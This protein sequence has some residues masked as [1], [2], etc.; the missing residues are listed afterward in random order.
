VR[1]LVLKQLPIQSSS[2]SLFPPLFVAMPKERRGKGGRGRG[3]GRGGERRGRSICR[4]LFTRLEIDF[5]RSHIEF[6]MK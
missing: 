2:F 5:V 4:H 6:H 3:E 1:L